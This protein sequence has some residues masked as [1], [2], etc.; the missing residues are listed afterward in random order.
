MPVSAGKVAISVGIT[1]VLAAACFAFTLQAQQPPRG[2]SATAAPHVSLVDEYCLSCHDE[3]H[4]KGDLEL[5]SVAADEM[6]RHPGVWEKVVRKLRDRQMP[7]VGKERPDEATYDA[8]I[9]SLERSL[10]R[11]AAAHPNPGR[12]ATLRRLTRTEYQN[13][14]RDL[15]AL[16]VDVTALLPADDSSYGFDNVTVGDLS[17]T[18]LDRYVSA[19]EK[20]SRLAV[21]RPSRSPGGDTIR[22]PPD[23][24]QEEHV[25]GLPV[26]TRGG[27]VVPYTFPLD[28]EYEIQIRLTRDRDEHVEGLSET[29][30]LELLVDRERVQLFTV[31]P[32]QPGVSGDQGAHATLDR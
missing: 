11:A 8:V 23:V 28:G 4:K 6:P 7:P 26:G 24:T 10:D 22:I 14:I 1:G 2:P 30:D 9:S 5:A 15:L 16:D 25:E 18:L 29:H 27:A 3:D 20:I 31:K 12:T 13:A 19:A 32:P 17:P 21:G